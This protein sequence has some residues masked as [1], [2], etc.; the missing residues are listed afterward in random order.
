MYFGGGLLRHPSQLYEAFFEGLVL[1]VILWAHRN[2]RKLSGQFLP[3]YLF[4]YGSF[5]F[6]IEFFRE[7]DPQLGLFFGALTLNQ[8]FSILIM[9]SAFAIG[10]SIRRKDAKIAGR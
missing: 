10:F 1:F 9:F 8:L 7:P 3:M 6:F 5:R 2:N 4:G